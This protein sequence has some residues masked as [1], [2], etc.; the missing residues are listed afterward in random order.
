MIHITATHRYSGRSKT[1][2]NKS[3]VRVFSGKDEDKAYLEIAKAIRFENYINDWNWEIEDIYVKGYR[4]W[5]SD[6]GNYSRAGY[7]MD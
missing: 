6:I 1:I 5:I 2:G 4:K 7:R 3:E